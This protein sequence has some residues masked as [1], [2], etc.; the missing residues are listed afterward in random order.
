MHATT[1]SE[2]GDHSFEGEVEGVYVW[3]EEREKRNLVIIIISKMKQNK[4]L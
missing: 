2:R 1:V 4:K 3:R